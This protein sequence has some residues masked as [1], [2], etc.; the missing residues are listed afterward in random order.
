MRKFL[1]IIG[2]LPRAWRL[3]V[4]QIGWEAERAR[5]A[6]EESDRGWAPGYSAL[7]RRAKRLGWDGMG[8][9]WGLCS[10]ACVRTDDCAGPHRD[11][12]IRLALSEV[13]NVLARREML[14]CGPV[15]RAN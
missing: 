7:A 2:I 4:A 10:W 15:P 3:A 5:F 9:L 13:Q 6:D 12:G 14:A 1:S 8:S 11:R